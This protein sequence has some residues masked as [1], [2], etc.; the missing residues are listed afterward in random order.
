MLQKKGE[1]RSTE[2]RFRTQSRQAKS[3]TSDG[4]S[5]EQHEERG[6]EEV[7]TEQRGEKSKDKTKTHRSQEFVL[8]RHMLLNHLSGYNNILY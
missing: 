6:T 1:Q 2:D 7:K 5:R 4:Y 8:Q 3:R